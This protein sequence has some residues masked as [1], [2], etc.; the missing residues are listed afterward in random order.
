MEL[1]KKKKKKGQL[2]GASQTKRNILAVEQI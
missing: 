1:G 2:V